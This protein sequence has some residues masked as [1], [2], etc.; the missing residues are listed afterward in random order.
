MFAVLDVHY[1]GSAQPLPTAG[2]ELDYLD[3][4]SVYR[5]VRGGELSLTTDTHVYR[6]RQN[7]IDYPDESGLRP[8]FTYPVPCTLCLELRGPHVQPFFETRACTTVRTVL[9]YLCEIV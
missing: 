4:I 9:W 3:A 2:E 1:A 5:S 7:Y 8:L 6:W